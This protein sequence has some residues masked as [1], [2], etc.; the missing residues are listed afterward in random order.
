MQTSAPTITKS[1]TCWAQSRGGCVKKMTGEHVF[2]KT[3]FIDPIL[4]VKGCA[5]PLPPQ[6]S[7][8]NL[9]SKVLCKRHNEELSDLDD[10]AGKLGDALRNASRSTTP[11]AARAR[12]DGSKLERWCLKTGYNML[13][14]GWTEPYGP[15]AVFHPDPAM[16]GLIFGG[17]RISGTGGLYGINEPGQRREVGDQVIARVIKS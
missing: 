5:R 10:E 16:V 2:S 7:R 1:K 9:Q 14:S 17:G 4:S 12:I 3:V 13:A 11:N 8:K 6:V 15:N